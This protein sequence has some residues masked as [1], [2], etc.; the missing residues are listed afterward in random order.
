MIIVIK[1]PTL[2]STIAD[3]VCLIA[4]VIVFCFLDLF[5]NSSLNL[6]PPPLLFPVLLHHPTPPHKPVSCG[7]QLFFM[8]L[9][10]VWGIL[11][12]QNG[13]RRSEP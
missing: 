9:G 6:Y 8:L 3:F 7:F 11:L 4:P 1:N 13:I 12:F 2:L 5:L 10:W